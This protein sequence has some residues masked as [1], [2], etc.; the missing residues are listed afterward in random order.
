MARL[1]T[2]TKPIIKEKIM[3]QN[4]LNINNR[5]LQALYKQDLSSFIQMAFKTLEP[6]SQYHHS[7]HIDLIA[8]YLM[9]T[10]HGDKNN[11]IINMPPRMMKSLS[12]SVALCCLDIR[13]SPTN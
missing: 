12:V 11:L 6:Y 7:P 9:Q 3:K 4:N 13:Q 10:Y 2:I 5:Q 1:I 8:D